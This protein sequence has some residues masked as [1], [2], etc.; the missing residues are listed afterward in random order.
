[1][2]KGEKER[3]KCLEKTETLLGTLI[4]NCPPKKSTFIPL[5]FPTFT[6]KAQNGQVGYKFLPDGWNSS[7]DGLLSDDGWPSM[8][9]SDT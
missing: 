3:T 8:T 9:L 6:M 5:T 7:I 1:M 2:D 4:W